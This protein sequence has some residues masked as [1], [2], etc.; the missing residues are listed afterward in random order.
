MERLKDARTAAAYS[1][2]DMSDRIQAPLE[3]YRKWEAG[4]EKIPNKYLYAVVRLL[5]LPQDYFKNQ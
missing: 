1:E 5:N 3:R 4:L 2:A